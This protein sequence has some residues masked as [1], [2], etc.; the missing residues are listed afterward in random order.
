MFAGFSAWCRGLAEGGIAKISQLQL[1]QPV[2]TWAGRCYC[3][4]NRSGPS[5]GGPERAPSY[6]G[7][8][9]IADERGVQEYGEAVGANCG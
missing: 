4:A 8:Q 3:S 6:L 1:A 9:R 2:L 7:R 5:P